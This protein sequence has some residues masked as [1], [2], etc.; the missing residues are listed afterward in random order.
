MSSYSRKQGKNKQRKQKRGGSYVP[1]DVPSNIHPYQQW[2]SPTTSAPPSQYNAGLYTGPSFQGP[3]GNIPVTPTT[4]SMINGNLR[5]AEP[6]MDALTQYVGANR[7]GNNYRAV[8]GI[9]WYADQNPAVKHN[10][11][12]N[13][14][15]GGSR[16]KRSQRR[17]SQQN[18][19]LRISQRTRRNSRQR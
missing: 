11:I 13:A 6:P 2:D 19:R 14:T 17:K 4:P 18:I 12:C 1:Y 8:P 16:K 5:S 9:S 15:G 3:Y 10:I 7:M